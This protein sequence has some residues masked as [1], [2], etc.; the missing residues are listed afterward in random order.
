MGIGGVCV[1]FRLAVPVFRGHCGVRGRDWDMDTPLYFLKLK[2]Q[3][4]FEGLK[5]LSRHQIAPHNKLLTSAP[6]TPKFLSYKL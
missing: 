4:D 3:L 6:P 2:N 5:S 1:S